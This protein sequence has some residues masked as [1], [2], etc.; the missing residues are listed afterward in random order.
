MPW[1]VQCTGLALLMLAGA[2]LLTD[3]LLWEPGVT[4]WNVQRIRPGMTFE[5][6][7]ALLGAHGFLAGGNR[8]AQKQEAWVW[9]GQSGF[10]WVIVNERR[11][12]RMAW[13]VSR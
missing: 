1:R 11:E 8:N 3:A 2:F 7:E 9:D 5:E 13:W 10:A 12:V 6:V 4:E